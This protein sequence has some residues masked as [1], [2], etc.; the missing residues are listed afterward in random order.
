MKIT[1]AMRDRAEAAL[2]KYGYDLTPMDLE[3]LFDAIF[4]DAP[5]V[6][7]WVEPLASEWTAYALETRALAERLHPS[8]ENRDLQFAEAEAIEECAAELRERA[9]RGDT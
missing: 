6:P 8:N 1:D 5:E 2:E 7:A 4:G 9:T 3:I